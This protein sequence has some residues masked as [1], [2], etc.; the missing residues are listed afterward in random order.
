MNKMKNFALIKDGVVM[1][2]IVWSGDTSEWQP[3][4]GV[5]AVEVTGGVGIGDIY[6]NGKFSRPEAED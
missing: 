4:A 6:E 5:I 2:V 3:P 1:N